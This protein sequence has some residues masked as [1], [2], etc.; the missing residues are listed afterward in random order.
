VA[1]GRARGR[2]E[3]TRAIEGAC[4]NIAEAASRKS[5]ADAARA[6]AIARGEA[7]EA[8]AAVEVVA[9]SGDTSSSARPLRP[10]RVRSRRRGAHAD[11]A[12]TPTRRTRRRGAHADAA[13]TPGGGAAIR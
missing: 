12:H 9:L 4:L 13:L 11:A 8:C 6:F 5:R 10:V 7:M 2:D 1:L 3:A